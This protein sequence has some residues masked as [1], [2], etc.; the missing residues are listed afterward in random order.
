MS[1]LLKSLQNSSLGKAAS[2][3]AYQSPMYDWTLNAEDIPERLTIK[4]VD[5]WSGCRVKG[6]QVCQGIF[7]HN[8]ATFALYGENWEPIGADPASLKHVHSFEWLRDLRTLGGQMARVQATELTRSWMRQYDRWH[9]VA[10]EP[11][12]LS[13]RLCMWLS[14]FDILGSS[15]EDEEFH[16]LFFASLM[17]QSRHLHHTF[18]ATEHNNLTALRIIKGLIYSG[19]SLNQPEWVAEGL[20]ALT[21]QL[22]H[23]I[24]YD[25]GHIS[26]APDKL[27]AALH[28]LLDIRIALT[29]A[30]IPLPESV[31]LNIE[32]MVPAIKFFRYQDKGFALFAGSQA[33]NPDFI[34]T[35]IA[36]AG[37]SGKAVHSLPITGYEKITHGR[38][39]LIMDI[40]ADVQASPL[41]FEFTYGKER[42]I[43]NCGNHP[44]STDWQYA[45]SQTPAYST[46][47][48]N[49]KSA[50]PHNADHHRIDEKHAT[51][52]EGSHDGFVQ[53]TRGESGC[54]P[55]RDK[56]K[57]GELGCKPIRDKQTQGLTHTRRV[58]LS[59]KGRDLCGED[60]FTSDTALAKP[61]DIAIRFH[62][63][64]D[65]GVSLVQNGTSALLKL[66]HG[67]GW[68]F[69]HSA[70]HL[71]LEDSIYLGEGTQ[72]RKTKQLVIYGQ[73]VDAQSQIQWS[74]HKE[75]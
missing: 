11:E 4:P 65:V 3:L 27:L 23:Q 57:R 30:N 38:G 15:L 66:R 62:L 61:A 50:K 8:G 48:L 10:W 24:N 21:E 26:R 33:G 69:T 43:T 58:Y 53:E 35:I 46:A 29:A 41:A 49:N 1:T 68:R 36:Q 32:R 14:H 72:P 60:K 54:K 22:D 52:L 45:L 25:G 16:D 13:T 34:D 17:R 2:N 9:A 20:T 59:D 51:S 56:Q 42:F 40:G 44:S 12:T 74:L 67:G 55:E 39:A 64:P 31:Q 63:H 71:V 6:Q 47:T 5:A 37:V 7:E 18:K 19:L 75:G 28:I 70:G 73:A